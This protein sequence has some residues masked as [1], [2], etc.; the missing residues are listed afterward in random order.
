MND[1]LDALRQPE[2]L[3]VLLNPLPIYGLAMGALALVAALISR[4]R[5]AIFIALGLIVLT[6]GSAWPV[7]GLGQQ[8]YE[9]VNTTVDPS[10][11]EWLEAHK[12]RAEKLI[13]AFYIL[14]LVAAT[15]IAI[16]QRWP[17][18]LLPLA[19][20]SLLGALAVLGAGSY[21]A[22]A[23]G[24]VRHLEFRKGGLSPDE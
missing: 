6:A 16:P 18:S 8:A 5:P 24:K 21:I 11:Q 23:G 4:S 13:P 15:G 20:L 10:G 14:A 7:Y 12:H 2:Y 17:K 22:H 1:L 9:K 3:H 19:L